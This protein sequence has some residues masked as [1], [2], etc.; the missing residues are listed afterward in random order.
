MIFGIILIVPV[1]LFMLAVAGRKRHPDIKKFHQWAY[2]HRGC[3]GNGIPENSIEA[4]RIAKSKGYGVELD[5][6]LLADG[7]LAVVHDSC[8]MRTT[9][10]NKEIENLTQEQLSDCF[11]EGT[12][13][14]IPL[15]KEVLA[16]FDGQTPI[17]IELK[18]KGDNYARL[19]EATCDLL[20]GY[21][22]LYCIES[23][24]PRCILWLKK[25]RNHIVR[26]QLA[27]NYFRSKNCKMSWIV[28]FV[29][30]NHLVNFIS[31]PDFIAYNYADRKRIAN[32]I[33]RNVW[34]MTGVA[35]TIHSRKLYDDVIREGWLPIFEGFEP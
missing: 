3:H 11:L 25:Y 10:C 24:D 9:G 13:Q 30:S 20:A 17:I 27:E 5:V 34:K 35:W 33:C 28:K 18:T 2:A 23:F 29:M 1:L 14:R 19:C 12:E 32:W 6:H 7:N 16:L 26:G 31:K 4:F 8:L 21:S 22:G 15:L